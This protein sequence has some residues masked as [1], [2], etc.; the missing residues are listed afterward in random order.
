MTQDNIKVYDVDVIDGEKK[1]EVVQ[2]QDFTSPQ[3]LYAQLIGRVRKYHPSADITQIE[4][5]YK[6]AH[7]AHEGQ[8]RKSGEPICSDDTGYW[9]AKTP[10]EARKTVKRLDNFVGEVNSARTGL[11][12]A[13]IQMRTVT[14]ITEENVLITVKVG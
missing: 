6:I 7:D 2:T 8:L 10:K 3:E 5:A 4:K 14:K 1:T 11:A 9:I 12:V 13:A